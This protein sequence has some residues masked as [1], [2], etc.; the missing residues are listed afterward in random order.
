M[1]PDDY[2]GAYLAVQHLEIAAARLWV[3]QRPSDWPASQ[4]RLRAYKQAVKDFALKDDPDLIEVG[5]WSTERLSGLQTPLR[6]RRLT[7][8]LPVMTR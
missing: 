2:Q 8:S 7:A 4:D 5:D 3:Y 1:L 6:R